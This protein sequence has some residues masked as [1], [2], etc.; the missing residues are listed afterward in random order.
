MMKLRNDDLV[1][2]KQQAGSVSS[3]GKNFGFLFKPVP[4]GPIKRSVL[5]N[6]S[7]IV[8]YPDPS[9]IFG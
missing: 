6:L 4:A 1:K 2:L 8:P 5:I 9:A 3:K 7:C